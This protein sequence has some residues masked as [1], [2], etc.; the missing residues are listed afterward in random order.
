VALGEQSP[1]NNGRSR[2]CRLAD[3]LR[4]LTAGRWNRDLCPL[5]MTAPWRAR[6]VVR[7]PRL[8]AAK[9]KLRK[10]QP[11]PE[12]ALG[13][14]VTD[15]GRDI[16]RIDR[17][18]E[19]IPGFPA[20]D[21]VPEYV[22]KYTERRGH[23]AASVDRI[24]LSDRGGQGQR[25]PSRYGLLSSEGSQLALGPVPGPGWPPRYGALSAWAAAVFR[26]AWPG[27]LERSAGNSWRLGWV[28]RW[29]GSGGC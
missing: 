1:R 6:R 10:H 3:C 17:T 9:M 19:H 11:Q 14:D 13:L 5:E 28:S 26:R 25:S 2:A 7:K 29:L 8:Q 22:M 16:I 21:Q 15:I 18:A 24:T 27:P 4:V 23:R 12:V 20:A